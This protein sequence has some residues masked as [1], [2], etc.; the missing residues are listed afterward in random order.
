MEESTEHI[1]AKA[2]RL[3]L[4]MVEI[5][6][7]VLGLLLAIA[8]SLDIQRERSRFVETALYLQGQFD[9]QITQNLVA[10]HGFAALLK[11][12]DPANRNALSAYSRY[13]LTRHPHIYMFQVAQVVPRNQLESFTQH[14]QQ[15]GSSDFRVKTFPEDGSSL[16]QPVDGKSG[17]YFPIIFMEP[18]FPKSI[19]MLGLDLGAMEYS[20]QPILLARNTGSSIP[21]KPFRLPDQELGYMIVQAVD[22]ADK[23]LFAVLVTKSKTFSQIIDEAAADRM[24]LAVSYLR[25]PPGQPLILLQQNAHYDLS[26]LSGLLPKLTARYALGGSEQPMQLDVEEQLGFDD[27]NWPVLMAI[28][29]GSLITVP[30]MLAYSRARHRDEM[31]RLKASNMLFAQ[32]NFDALTGLPNRQLFLNRLEQA[33]AVAHRQG[34][35]HAVLYLDLDGFKGINDYYGHSIGDRVLIRAAKIFSKCVREIDTVA[36]L[37]GD[38]FVILLQDI[39]GRAGAEFVASKIRKAFHSSAPMVTEKGNIPPMLGT[40]IGIA[41]Y[42]QDGTSMDVLIKHADTDMY[43]DKAG[44]KLAARQSGTGGSPSPAT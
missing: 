11:T 41:V 21:S 44:R 37:G 14:Q 1:Q 2:A 20:R 8:I 39:D 12:E 18:M 36:R 15:I 5:F 24:S 40:S 32:A 9:T 7:T 43:K 33:L 19:E 30:V 16:W 6:L 38:E 4:V 25:R 17:D 34:L 29:A 31:A 3:N 42:P 28:I 22:R 27:L 23:Q 26:S 10:L 35:M 13:L